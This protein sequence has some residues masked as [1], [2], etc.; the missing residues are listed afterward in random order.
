MVIVL[1]IFL[2]FAAGAI[3]APMEQ[4]MSALPGEEKQRLGLGVFTGNILW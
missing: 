3:F 4:V 2:G 1:G